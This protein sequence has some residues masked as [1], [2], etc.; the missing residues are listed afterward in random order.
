MNLPAGKLASIVSRVVAGGYGSSVA[1]WVVPAT[2]SVIVARTGPGPF[3]LG[4]RALTE[5]V[6]VW[7]ACSFIAPV[8]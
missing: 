2:A 1:H 7:I 4:W 5:T 6:P 8:R 3:P